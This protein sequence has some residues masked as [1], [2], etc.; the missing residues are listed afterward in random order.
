MVRI[1]LE[2]IEKYAKINNVPIMMKDGIEYLT[3]YIK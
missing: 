1:Q 2:E 3:N